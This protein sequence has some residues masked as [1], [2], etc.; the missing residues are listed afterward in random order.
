MLAATP[1]RVM[2]NSKVGPFGIMG[3]GVGR[4][5]ASPPSTPRR[6]PPAVATARNSHAETVWLLLLMSVV[7]VGGVNLTRILILHYFLQQ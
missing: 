1:S 7:L 2:M 3:G 5:A 4:Q 6:S